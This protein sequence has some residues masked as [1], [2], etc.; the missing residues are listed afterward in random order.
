MAVLAIEDTVVFFDVMVTRWAV[1]GWVLGVNVRVVFDV[2]E[3]VGLC[4]TPYIYVSQPSLLPQVL[5][6]FL[7]VALGFERPR[8]K[9]LVDGECMKFV[10]SPA[11]L[12]LQR[13]ITIGIDIRLL[14]KLV[15]ASGFE[16]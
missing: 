12:A 9:R 14:F 8:I 5:C 6:H 13:F 3:P 16:S 1:F 2:V 11:Y 7:S 15:M 10:L 4:H